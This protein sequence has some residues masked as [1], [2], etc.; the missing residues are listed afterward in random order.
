MLNI[1]K[2]LKTISYCP[3]KTYFLHVFQP[4]SQRHILDETMKW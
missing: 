3:R 1:I 4:C 2:K